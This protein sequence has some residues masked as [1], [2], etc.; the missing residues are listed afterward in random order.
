M[1]VERVVTLEHSEL[2]RG[3]QQAMAAQLRRDGRL[4]PGMELGL[5]FYAPAPD[6]LYVVGRVKQGPTVLF[7]LKGH[8]PQLSAIAADL[9]LARLTPAE[10]RTLRPSVDVRWRVVQFT[11]ED[12][13]VDRFL[14]DVAFP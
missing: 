5:L 1:A 9:A 4:Q 13:V 14:A 11:G 6:D 2:V 12:E 3:V 10:Q 8:K 7:E